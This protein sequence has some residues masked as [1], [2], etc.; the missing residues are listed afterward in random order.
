MIY[1]GILA[2]A[3]SLEFNNGILYLFLDAATFVPGREERERRPL[4]K[5]KRPI[6]GGWA[7]Q[8]SNRGVIQGGKRGK[9]PGLEVE[10]EIEAGTVEAKKLL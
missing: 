7:E 2:G 5:G 4:S 3:L 1:L 9:R 8:G 10:A 6:K